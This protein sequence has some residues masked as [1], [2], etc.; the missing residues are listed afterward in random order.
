M[1]SADRTPAARRPKRAA[2]QAVATPAR[3]AIAAKR[4]RPIAPVPRGSTRQR[5]QPKRY[6]PE[7][8]D[9]DHTAPDVVE[10]PSVPVS[11]TSAA[12]A[13]PVA[14][15]SAATAPAAVMPVASASAAAVSVQDS[16]QQQVAD[17][18]Q[19]VAG[20]VG[21]VQQLAADTATRNAAPTAPDVHMAP[22]LPG[23]SV[24]EC[25]QIVTIH[26]APRP[27]MFAAGLPAGSHVSDTLKQK[28]WSDKYVD[29]S[30][31]LPNNNNPAYTMSMNDAGNV[32]TLQF[33]PQKRRPLTE[34][35]WSAA[36]DDYFAIYIQKH[37]HH[38]TDMITYSRHIKELMN[39]GADWRHYDQQFRSDR[40][41]S[42]CSWAT[43]RIDLQLTAMLKPTQQAYRKDH[44]QHSHQSYI[45]PFRSSQPYRQ[46]PIKPQ[47]GLPTGYC[48][49]YHSQSIRC[50]VEG[51]RYK[52]S[53]PKCNRAHPAFKP[54]ARQQPATK[55]FRPANP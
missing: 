43:V 21:V 55:Q 26:D 47:T 9:D 11:S 18:R 48:F 23:P 16:L 2:S 25:V 1:S 3:P 6:Q 22:A 33:A 54:C 44:T 8:S 52:H 4:Q 42:H 7:V 46:G 19:T 32:P 24:G 39:S 34:N 27:V 28:I 29:L 45:Q 20:L 36:W 17:L 13:M 50:T 10:A 31:L 41:F 15:T 37:T 35:E 30:E 53:C 5:R 38:I 14:S 40:E 51:C 12:T 49:A